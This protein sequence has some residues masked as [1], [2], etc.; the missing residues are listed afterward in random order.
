M[1]NSTF[2]KPVL[3]WLIALQVT[4]AAGAITVTIVA[5]RQMSALIQA[6]NNLSQQVG[7]L[8]RQIV[9][10]ESIIKT[11]QSQRAQAEAER[12]AMVQQLL[13]SRYAA[14]HVRAGINHYQRG[15]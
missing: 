14:D 11:L 13:K 6:K 10:Q 15:E 1:E 2:N 4:V 8:R 7:L 12:A 5:G 9:A 3:R